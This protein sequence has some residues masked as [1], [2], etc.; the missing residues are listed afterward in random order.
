LA[1][2]SVALTLPIMDSPGALV[3]AAR[4]GAGLSMHALAARAKVAYTTVSRIEHGQVDPTTGMLSRLM[5]AAGRQLELTSRE[6]STPR[7]ADLADAWT[8]NA[9]GQDRPDWTRVRAFL[10]F[11][12]QHPDLS[13]PA[14]VQAPVPSG[15]QFMDNLFAGIAEKA[16]LDPRRGQHP[17][18][19]AELL[20]AVGVVAAAHGLAPGWLNDSAAGFAPRPRSGFAQPQS[21]GR[22]D[23]HDGPRPQG[24]RPSW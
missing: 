19:D 20:S 1:Q 21:L 10:D 9:R 22:P 16:R 4:E 12:A 11:V 24:R 5:T 15:S 6:A 23:A 7:L 3:T 13:G 18:L 14:T 2:R 8:T 17:T